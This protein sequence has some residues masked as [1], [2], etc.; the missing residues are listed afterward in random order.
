MSQRTRRAATLGAMLLL[1]LCQV[2]AQIV[3]YTWTGRADGTSWS[4]PNNWLGNAVPADDLVNTRVVFNRVASGEQ[5]AYV[6]RS[7]IFVNQLSVQGIVRPISFH[8]PWDSAHIGSG[9]IIYNPATALR[10]ELLDAVHLR[11]NQ[12][13]NIQSGTLVVHGPIDDDHFEGQNLVTNNFL[14]EKT[15]AGTLQ[16]RSAF[17]QWSGGLRLTAGRVVVQAVY[18][19]IFD[20]EFGF[21]QIPAPTQALGSGT[22][23]FNGGTLVGLETSVGGDFPVILR[24]NVVSN[25]LIASTK[26]ASARST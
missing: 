23:T 8:G 11:A 24:N 9:G 14:L 3:T 7:D 5:I 17:S 10:S 22:I 16:L 21:I 25:G 2:H 12:A 1:G 26:R 6:D 20:P 15:G 4:N 18:D 19:G 13:W